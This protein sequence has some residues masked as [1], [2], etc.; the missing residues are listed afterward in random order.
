[1]FKSVP[2]PPKTKKKKSAKVKE[3]IIKKQRWGEH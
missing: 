1:M 3:K 2:A